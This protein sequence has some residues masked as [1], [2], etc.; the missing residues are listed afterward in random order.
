MYLPLLNV[1][2]STSIMINAERLALQCLHF[3]S[4]LASSEQPSICARHLLAELLLLIL[5][6][7]P[8]INSQ[9]LLSNFCHK[10]SRLIESDAIYY[11]VWNTSSVAT[12]MCL[13][14]P[15]TALRLAKL[16]MKLLISEL[17]YILCKD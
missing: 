7:L 14:T 15:E 5:P 6:S 1:T 2:T 12:C 8:L 17:N 10:V 16:T 4:H 3:V 11:T 9:K 13:N